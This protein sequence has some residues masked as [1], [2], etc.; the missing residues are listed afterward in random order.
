MIRENPHLPYL[1]VLLPWTVGV[2]FMMAAAL[3]YSK[4]ASRQQVT[5]GIVTAHEAHNHNRYVYK[6][7]LDGQEYTGGETP[8]GAEP[9]VGELVRVYFDP[10]D[11][12]RNGLTDFGKRRERMR[13]Q[14][15]GLLILTTAA[16]LLILALGKRRTA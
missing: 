4:V 12:S 6:F 2:I 16:G 10:L 8:L 1:V 14:A 3:D 5:T 9:K 15:V 7:Q 13:G 11:P